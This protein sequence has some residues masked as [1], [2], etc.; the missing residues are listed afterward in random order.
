MQCISVRF[1]DVIELVSCS[2]QGQK[3]GNVQGETR[4]QVVFKCCC[5][6][7]G[8]LKILCLTDFFFI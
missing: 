8:D 6:T 3:R 5:T 7:E 2:V 4:K 1:I